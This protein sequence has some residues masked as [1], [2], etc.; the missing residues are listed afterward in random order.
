LG[1]A[2]IAQAWTF[3]NGLDEDHFGVLLGDNGDAALVNR[4]DPVTN[5]EAMTVHFHC[6]RAGAI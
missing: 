5:G 1:T 3:S 6:P 4:C 2:S